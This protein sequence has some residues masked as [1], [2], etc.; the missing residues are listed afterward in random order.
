[1]ALPA[2]D[3]R[4]PP[5]RP[6]SLTAREIQTA[7]SREREIGST[8]QPV[9]PA[10]PVSAAPFPADREREGLELTF[11]QAAGIASPE[12]QGP[13]TET[14]RDPALPDWAQ[15]LLRQTGGNLPDGTHMTAGGVHWDAGSQMN[16][17]APYASPPQPAVRTP[18]ISPVRP[19]ASAGQPADAGVVYREPKA[20]QTQE[21]PHLSDTELRRAADRV[22]RMI[23]ER[24]RR[25][26][27][28]SGK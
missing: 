22:Y 23:E 4:I 21:P 15:K 16:W 1:M 13:A 27:R 10:V 8:V 7:R 19:V 12:E 2:S 17:N 11:A 5:F 26:L 9:G 24:L 3:S 18:Q 28:R 20:G 14:F 25:E 6:L